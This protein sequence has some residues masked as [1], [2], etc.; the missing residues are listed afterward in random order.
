MGRCRKEI[1]L[2]G[3]VRTILESN[4]KKRNINFSLKQR[5]Q[6]I[7]LSADGKQ[8]QEIARLLGIHYNIVGKWRSRFL[9]CLPVLDMIEKEIPE[10][11]EESITT[12][13]SD[14]PRSGA[15][16]KYTQEQRVKIVDLACKNPMDYQY[17]VSQWSTTLLAKEAKKQGIVDDIS[18]ASVNRFLKSG[19][20][21]AAQNQVL[22]ELTRK[23]GKS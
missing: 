21:K 14:L 19:G 13:L 2:S 3:R 20:F 23:A 12:L 16:T 1:N 15:P 4:G 10:E 11:L 17:E 18:A 7:L 9:D 8:N 6:I 5:S 22:A